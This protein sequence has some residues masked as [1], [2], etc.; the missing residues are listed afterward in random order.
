M[1]SSR[2]APGPEVMHQPHFAHNLCKAPVLASAGTGAIVIS[3]R[4]QSSDIVPDI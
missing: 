3:A 1:A 2:D 4:L